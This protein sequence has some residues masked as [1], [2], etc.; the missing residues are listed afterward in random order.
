VVAFGPQVEGEVSGETD[1]PLSFIRNEVKG[2]CGAFSIV[3]VRRP[4]VLLALMP[5][6]RRTETPRSAELA[7]RKRR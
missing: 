7:S 6:A 4:V 1:L 5:A 3:A 2:T